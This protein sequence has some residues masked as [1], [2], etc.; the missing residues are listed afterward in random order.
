MAD[1][2]VGERGCAVAGRTPAP[3]AP[4]TCSEAE[5]STGCLAVAGREWAVAGREARKVLRVLLNP[6]LA[7]SA[8]TAAFG[9]RGPEAFGEDKRAA[10]LGRRVK[11]RR[12]AAVAGRPAVV[13]LEAD[14]PPAV[15][16]R[17]TTIGVVI[18]PLAP[19]TQGLAPLPPGVCS[20]GGVAIGGRKEVKDLDLRRAATVIPEGCRTRDLGGKVCSLSRGLDI[21]RV[22]GVGASFELSSSGFGVRISSPRGFAA[23]HEDGVMGGG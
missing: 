10:E 3:P 12:P 2:G 7:A 15:A 18:R 6:E 14:A 22:R 21:V 4:C 13:F 8:C 20:G 19:S 9:T 17:G 16:G 23:L 5:R 11:A 1:F